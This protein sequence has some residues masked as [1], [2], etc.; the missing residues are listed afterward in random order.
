M[1][2]TTLSFR[3]LA[4]VALIAAGGAATMILLGEVTTLPKDIVI[5]AGI[6]VMLLAQYPRREVSVGWF[7]FERLLGGLAVVGSYR[8]LE[9][10][11]GISVS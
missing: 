1:T 11:F 2:E 7:V 3:P 8:V 6:T 5:A 4:H 9:Q 10:L